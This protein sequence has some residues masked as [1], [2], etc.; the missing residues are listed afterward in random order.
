MPLNVL[1]CASTDTYNCILFNSLS[2]QIKPEHSEGLSQHITEN[3]VEHHKCLL[4]LKCNPQR[5]TIVFFSK[6]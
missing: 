6:C 2:K 3:S 5:I 4:K 1:I